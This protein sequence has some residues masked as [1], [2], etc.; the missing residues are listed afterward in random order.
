MQAKIRLALQAAPATGECVA[1]GAAV[2][3][4]Q[5][6]AIG[7]TDLRR[8]ALLLALTEPVESCDIAALEV[9]QKVSLGE[10]VT[11]V[12]EQLHGLAIQEVAALLHGLQ[13][14]SWYYVTLPR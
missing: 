14:I 5:A 1:L 10:S 2:Q 8:A 4:A 3:E 7:C 6:A 12:Q 9:C 11:T 13:S